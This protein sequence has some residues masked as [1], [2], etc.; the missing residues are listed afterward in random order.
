MCRCPEVK[1]SDNCRLWSPTSAA[2]DLRFTCMSNI[3]LKSGFHQVLQD[4]DSRALTAFSF[5][6]Y[7]YQLRDVPFGLK[8]SMAGFIRNVWQVLEDML[9]VGYCEI[10]ISSA[11]TY[12]LRQ[13]INITKEY[14][15]CDTKL[16]VHLD[17]I[18]RLTSLPLLCY[19]GAVFT[20]PSKVY[21]QSYILIIS[22]RLSVAMGYFYL[23]LVVHL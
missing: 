19:C 7:V 5:Y 23:L 22:F 1:F 18:F 21:F 8:M 14:L 15:Y 12:C 10:K 3:D 2:T 11:I 17:L 6:G 4:E 9:L 16:S 20:N 13:I